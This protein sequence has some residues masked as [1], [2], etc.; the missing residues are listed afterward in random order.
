MFGFIKKNS[1]NNK[2]ANKKPVGN[3]PAGYEGQEQDY[4]QQEIKMETPSRP[5]SPKFTYPRKGSKPL[6]STIKKEPTPYM[7]QE[8]HYHRGEMKVETPSPPASPKF[9]YPRKGS[10]PLPSTIKQEPTPYVPQE[11]TYARHGKR[12]SEYAQQ[13]FY[14]SREQSYDHQEKRIKTE[15]EDADEPFS[16][17]RKG[18]G[19]FDAKKW[20]WSG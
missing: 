15:P 12:V 17:A 5:A 14:N 20:G 7:P 2:A 13:A 8:P 11:P 3:D 18:R 4:Y 19:A 1:K 10:K 6:P 16:Y 9:T